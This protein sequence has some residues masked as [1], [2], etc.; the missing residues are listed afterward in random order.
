MAHKPTRFSTAR[1]EAGVRVQLIEPSALEATASPAPGHVDALMLSDCAHTATISPTSGQRSNPK[2]SGGTV[3]TMTTDRCHSPRH[4]HD[5]TDQVPVRRLPA[6]KWRR[7]SQPPRDQRRQVAN[8]RRAA[9][10]VRFGRNEQASPSCGTLL[11]RHHHSVR[12]YH[13]GSGTYMCPRLSPATSRV[14]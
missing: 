12:R 4:R 8:S 9:T 10:G 6:V 2:M 11:S 5:H 3:A 13:D 7:R 1:S 14:E